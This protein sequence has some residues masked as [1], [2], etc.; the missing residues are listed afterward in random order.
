MTFTDAIILG[1]VQGLTEFLPISSSGHLVLA[2][3]IL[4]IKRYGNEIEVLVHLGTLASILVVFSNDIKLIL[5][6][7]LI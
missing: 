2:Q 5:E 3:H 7:M 6:K 1:V 4:G